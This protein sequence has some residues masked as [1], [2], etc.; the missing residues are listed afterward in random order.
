MRDCNHIFR[1]FTFAT[2]SDLKLTLSR[3]K[4]HV[5]LYDGVPRALHN[6][7]S[8][9]MVLNNNTFCGNLADSYFLSIN[10]PRTLE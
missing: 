6:D 8:D 10:K 4:T 7:S 2:E 9:I 1:I 3:L 5:V